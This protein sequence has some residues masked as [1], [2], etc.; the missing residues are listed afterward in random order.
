M[1]CFGSIVCVSM[2]TNLIVRHEKFQ[3]GQYYFS[4]I[5]RLTY[6]TAVM[7]KMVEYLYCFNCFKNSFKKM[8]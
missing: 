8:F 5:Y 7:N 3:N 6:I 1:D 4:M 2:L